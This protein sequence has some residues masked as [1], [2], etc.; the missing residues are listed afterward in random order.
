METTD[1]N[2][3]VSLRARVQAFGGFFNKY[4]IT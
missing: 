4:G 3:K 2:N 1:S